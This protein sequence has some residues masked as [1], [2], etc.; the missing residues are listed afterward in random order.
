MSVRSP[1]NFI[2]RSG[3]SF[4]RTTGRAGP[5][6]L[7]ST[8]PTTENRP[9]PAQSLGD[10]F[11]ETWGS[12]SSVGAGLGLS[13]ADKKDVKADLRAAGLS[14]SIADSPPL[15]RQSV[16]GAQGRALYRPGYAA[17]T[18]PPRTDP[19]LELFTNLLMKHGRK[20][21]AQKRIGEVLDV[22]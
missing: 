6:R 18:R 14:T 11:E 10:I 17:Q 16:D 4:T 22:M 8:S 7:L 15:D 1:L 19:L 21:E 5:S 2:A 20:A 9:T 13:S 12:S 3:I